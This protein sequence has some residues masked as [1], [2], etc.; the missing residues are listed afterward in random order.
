MI[1]VTND[2][3]IEA[4][5]IAALAEALS[6]LGQVIVAA[7]DRER[8]GAGHAL[9]LSQ[10]LRVHD[11][12][13]DRFRIDGTPTDCVHLG[14]FNLT[15]Q[16]PTLVVSGINRG[17]NVGDDVTYSGTVA[18][19]LE[20]TLLGIPSIAVSTATDDDGNVADYGPAARFAVTMA[21]RV[22]EHGL[23]E[24]QLLNVNLPQGDPKGV[25]ITRQGTRT[26]R[27]AVVERLDPSG[28]PYYWIAGADMTPAGEPDGDHAAIDQGYISVTP[29]DAN[30]TDTRGLAPLADW[31]LPLP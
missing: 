29:L 22:L 14:V 30:M 15:P 2:D 4:P 25:R 24:R 27:A 12:G 19:A 5:G 21:R 17:L 16:K 1:L 9:T 13:P 3:G 26:Y 11:A 7:P 6:A 23:P 18:G 10:P 28:R 31:E 8:S 20:G